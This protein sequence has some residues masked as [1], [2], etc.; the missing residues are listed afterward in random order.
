MKIGTIIKN[1]LNKNYSGN[2]KTLSRKIN[3]SMCE[4]EQ[5]TSDNAPDYLIFGIEE[6]SDV[7]IGSVWK[8]E[9]MREGK[10]VEFLSINI[11]DPSFET[12]LNVAAFLNSFSGDYEI[13]WRRRQDRPANNA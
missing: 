1:T 4:N 10:K 11:D 9:I 8:K 5:K 13:I 2:I 7:Q 12:S 3:F 6:N